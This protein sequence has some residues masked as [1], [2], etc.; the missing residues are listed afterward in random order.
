MDE[1]QLEINKLQDKQSLLDEERQLRI[2]LIESKESEI[3]RL[4]SHNQH[5]EKQAEKYVELILKAETDRTKLDARLEEIKAMTI[6]E[7]VL[8]EDNSFER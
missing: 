3:A 5:L 8:T 6:Q 2:D 7:G 1:L 4:M